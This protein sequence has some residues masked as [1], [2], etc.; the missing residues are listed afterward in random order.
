M[1]EYG[2][3]KVEIGENI[4]KED[5]VG[6]KTSRLREEEDIKRAGSKT[7]RETDGT[8]QARDNKRE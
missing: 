8:F 4:K 1:R 3:L 2:S 5:R 6:R 7:S